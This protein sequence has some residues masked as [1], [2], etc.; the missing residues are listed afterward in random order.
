VSGHAQLAD[1]LVRRG[2]WPAALSACRAALGVDPTHLDARA[3]LVACLIRT[4]N[5]EQARAEF[6]TLMALKPP[7]QA[8]LEQWFAEQC[9]EWPEGA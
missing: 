5:K 3:L 8:E 4:G 9:V 1:L 7:K 2:D 6:A